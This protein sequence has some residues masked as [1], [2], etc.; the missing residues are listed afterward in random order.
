MTKE[1]RA[2]REK[3]KQRREWWIEALLSGRFKQTVSYLHVTKLDTNELGDPDMG[4][5]Q[6][7]GYC[8]L[9]VACVVYNRHNPRYSLRR[10]IEVDGYVTNEMF[11]GMVGS[12][13]VSTS[14][15]LGISDADESTLQAMN[16]SGKTFAVI[17]RLI[18]KLPIELQ[19]AWT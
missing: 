6:N 4:W 11:D 5:P 18:R 7:T 1:E 10:K 16:D 8:C 9:G 13:P 3:I 2:K 17:A 15:W 12:L 14:R 19:E